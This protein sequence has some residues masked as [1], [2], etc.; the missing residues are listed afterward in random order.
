MSWLG[1]EFS[2]ESMKSLADAYSSIYEGVEKGG[3]IADWRAPEK[4]DGVAAKPGAPK[5]AKKDE[6]KNEGRAKAAKSKD[7]ADKQAEANRAG[8]RGLKG[9]LD[10]AIKI[11]QDDRSEMQKIRDRRAAKC[12][13]PKNP[14]I[15]QGLREE[16]IEDEY[17]V[18]VQDGLDLEE[19]KKKCK[20]GYK[21][22]SEKGKCVKKKKK[23]SSKTTVIVKTGGRGGY[24]GGLYPGYGSGG[25]SNNG[26]GGEGETESG[27][28][29][30][31]GDGGGGGGGE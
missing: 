21:W 29:D 22:D 18:S 23:S 2:R 17:C 1:N 26:D 16:L 11:V 4:R 25:G 13:K 15:N 20:D 28:G 14:N 8:R 6:D 31:G 5:V 12:Q 9:D 27:G 7:P 3:Q 30:G 10:Q 24:Y 19:G